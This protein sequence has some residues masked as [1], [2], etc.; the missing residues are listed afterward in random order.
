M[1]SQ[2]ADHDQEFDP[3]PMATQGNAMDLEDQME[4]ERLAEEQKKKQRTGESEYQHLFKD[5][6]EIE[7]SFPVTE[8][9]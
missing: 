9:G 4:E 2:A 7:K 8:K 5:G 6:Y 3:D 1:D